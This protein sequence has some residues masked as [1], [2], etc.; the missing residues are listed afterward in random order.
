MSDPI[1]LLR[2]YLADPPGPDEKFTDTDLVALIE[3][4]PDL[5][6]A[7]AD[8]WRARAGVLAEQNFNATVDGATMNLGDLWKHCIDM[9]EHYEQLGG[10]SLSSVLLDTE[11]GGGASSRA[12]EF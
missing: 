6:A 1:K 9:A 5:Y 7:A 10:G 4:N 8:G 2:V 3:T 12:S 11:A